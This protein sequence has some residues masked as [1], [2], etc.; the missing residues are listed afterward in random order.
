MQTGERAQQPA[1]PSAPARREPDPI[2]PAAQR[3]DREQSAAQHPGTGAVPRERRTTAPA[4]A[5]E[6]DPDADTGDHPAQRPSPDPRG[7][8]Q[9]RTRQTGRATGTASP[10][11]EGSISH[12]SLAP[13]A[14]PVADW[15]DDI[16]SAARTPR[17]PGPSWPDSPAVVRPLEPQEP[18]I[19]PDA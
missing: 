3:P 1:W 2:A 8:A 6:P 14:S 19:E 10:A 5:E 4:T 7:P 13:D 18:G 15:R 11:A 9:T 12:S 17:Q 16:I